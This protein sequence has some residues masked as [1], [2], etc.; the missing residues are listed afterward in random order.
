[1]RP[2]VR[3]LLGAVPIAFVL[4]WAAVSQ[5]PVTD[6]VPA[7]LA[8]ALVGIVLVAAGL[9]VWS[10][11][12]H[13]RNGPLLVL[14]GYLW[15]VGDLVF[16]IGRVPL[17]GLLGFAFR[18]YYDLILA[19]VVLSFP[20]EAPVRRS[21]RVVVVSL[22][23][24]YL[25]RSFVRLA[26][27]AP[28]VGYPFESGANPFLVITDRETFR[29]LDLHLE[30]VAA[31]L[32]LVVAALA[33]ARLFQTPVS[34]R[35]LL[36]PVLTGG[37][38]GLAGVAAFQLLEVSH[39]DLGFDLIP[40][41]SPWWAPASYVI[42]LVMP[43]GILI[44]SL[45]LH[46][47]RYAVVDLVTGLDTTAGRA[48]LTGAL[49][50]A[51]DDPRLQL[52]FPTDSE[53][54]LD[55]NGSHADLHQQEDGRAVT[56]IASGGETLGAIVHDEALLEDPGLVGT[57]VATMRLAMDNERLRA[58]L[59]TQL[60]EVRASR[61]RIIEASDDARRRVER[62]L[63]DGA[64]QRLVALAL[65]LRLVR[66]AIGRE[67]DTQ[68]AVR[69]DE[70]TAELRGAIDDLRELARGL[71]PAI[72]REAG[73]AQ[74]LR[75]LA[76]RATIPVSVEAGD[77]GRLPDRVETTA[78]FVAAETLTNVARHAN[79][80]HAWVRAVVVGNDLCLEV[81]DDGQGGADVTAGTGLR[82]LHDRVAALDGRME[83]ISSAN[84][85]TTV[86][87]WVPCASS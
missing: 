12:P 85:G 72:L 29:W 76:E 63:H 34:G 10:R 16:V 78:W 60:A 2:G 84:Q 20:G 18:G 58:D 28:G 54:W 25:V 4:L 15:Y 11:R 83:V 52:L 55:A 74:A 51:L 40:W 48:H 24:V 42:R 82:G 69:L 56:M 27:A 9:I 36:A 75:S 49:R 64:Q 6:D 35:R 79:A 19:W 47:H 86:R 26:G 81:R 73:L 59:E 71:D 46:A 68:V 31:L 43:I 80:T 44:G 7:Y 30:L 3:F 5:P 8:D 14:A 17:M 50:R 67:P 39:F 70:A 38:V 37:A 1:M 45:R 87:A 57:L 66:T 62:D 13:S 32:M 41:D 53:G 33:L 22:V 61:A 77:L 21:E 23:G 65:R